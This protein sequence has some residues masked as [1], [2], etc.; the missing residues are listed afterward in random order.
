MALQASPL[1]SVVI[2]ILS[3]SETSVMYENSMADSGSG[4][5]GGTTVPVVASSF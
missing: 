3:G 5:F 2:G 4:V 1:N